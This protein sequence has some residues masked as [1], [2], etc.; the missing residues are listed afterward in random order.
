MSG[1]VVRRGDPH[2]CGAI[3]PVTGEAADLVGKRLPSL[4]SIVLARSLSRTADAPNRCLERPP[5]TLITGTTIALDPRLRWL[6]VTL[7]SVTNSTETMCTTT[8]QSG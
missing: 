1:A 4:I 2:D 3:F 5:G 8:V 6:G 7:K